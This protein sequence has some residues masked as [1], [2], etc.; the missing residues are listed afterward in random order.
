MADGMSSSNSASSLTSQTTSPNI[1]V[2]YETC[3]TDARCEEGGGKVRESAGKSAEANE[4][5]GGVSKGR[6]KGECGVRRRSASTG[7][8]MDTAVKKLDDHI[9][10]IWGGRSHT[11]SEDGHGNESN[12]CRGGPGKVH[13]GDPVRDGDNGIRC[14]KCLTWYHSA[15]QSIPK[16]AVNAAGRFSMLHWFCSACHA[17][18]FND[19][20]KDVCSKTKEALDVLENGVLKN[21]NDQVETMKETVKEHIKL[22][23]R[24]LRQQEE[25]SFEQTKLIERAVRLQHESKASYADMVRGSCADIAKEMSHKIDGIIGDKV[26]AQ[27]GSEPTKDIFTAVN[28]ALDKERR[29]LNVVVHNLPETAPTADQ[30]REKGDLQKFSAIIKEN[31]KLIIRASKCRVGKM[32]EDRPRLLVITLE[33]ME[34]KMELL[35]M[36]SELRNFTEWRNLYINPDLTPA[37]REANRQLRQE[38]ARRRAAGE[39][40]I[41]IRRGSI[42]KVRQEENRQ[43]TRQTCQNSKSMSDGRSHQSKQAEQ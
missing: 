10:T 37:E 1:S 27:S 41:V 17:S 16:A 38:L 18:V 21:V 23:N 43:S 9:F 7:E 42:V 24:A 40:N 32:L 12:V 29:K 4:T 19:V 33:N 8:G 22:V 26:Q 30:S 11:P 28:S 3:I 15:C 5:E 2:R 35:R 25:M 13:C 6:E 36:S 31:L 39:E 34:T 20:K 14:D